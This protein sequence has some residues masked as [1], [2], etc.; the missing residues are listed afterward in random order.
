LIFRDEQPHDITPLLPRDFSA[1]A[2][3]THLL[4]KE[5]IDG[6]ASRWTGIDFSLPLRYHGHQLEWTRYILA[7]ERDVLCSLG[8]YGCIF[9][10]MF[11]YHIDTPWLRAFCERWNYSTNTLFIDDRELTPTLWEIHQLTGLPVFGHY[12]DE[13]LLSED[14]LRDPS[15]H[16][17]SLR[18]VYRTYDQLRGHHSSVP[19][20]F[21]ISYFIDRLRSHPECYAST[22]DPFGTGHHGLYYDVPA[23]P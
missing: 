5:M 19:F 22:R 10:S 8:V 2:P 12:Y 18:E 15:L 7:R 1:A 23:L 20:R 11:R 9:L 3:L 21:W 6:E 16:P 13:F 17:A 14:D 4:G